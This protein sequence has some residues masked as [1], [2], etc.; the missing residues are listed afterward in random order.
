MKRLLK[1]RFAR[2]GPIRGIDR[3]PSGSPAV[4][5]LCPVADLARVKTITAIQSL[6][7][8]GMKMIAAKRAV[9]RM[10]EKGEVVVAVP[11]NEPGNG[12][13]SDLR[14][15]GIKAVRVGAGEVDIRALRQ[16]LD[17]TQEEFALRYNFKLRALQN[18]EQGRRPDAL[19][20]NYLRAIARNPEEVAKA[21][22]EAA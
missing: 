1:E 20:Q 21:Q 16:R 11:T 2:L 17:M 15:A 13:I 9:E 18:W 10:V 5:S 8:R 6:A 22:E 7:K 3:V 12:L 14:A 19:V 4:L